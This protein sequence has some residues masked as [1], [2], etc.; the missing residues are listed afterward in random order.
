MDIYAPLLKLSCDFSE[1][2]EERAPLAYRI[3]AIFGKLST[4]HRL[5][6]VEAVNKLS[7]DSVEFPVMEYYY[8]CRLLAGLYQ[9]MTDLYA[10]MN[11]G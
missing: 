8:R 6:Y 11:I 5:A 10:G 3:P 9:R 2:A 4:R 1:L 7:R